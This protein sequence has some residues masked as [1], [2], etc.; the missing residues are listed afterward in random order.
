MLSLSIYLQI[1]LG[2]LSIL[3]LK[4]S[5]DQIQGAAPVPV[6]IMDIIIIIVQ[7]G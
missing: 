5:S 2:H 4:I 6:P 1:D 3:N 7:V